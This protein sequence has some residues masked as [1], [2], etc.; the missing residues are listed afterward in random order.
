MN[1]IARFF[2][3]A[4]AG[5]KFSLFVA[6]SILQ[7]PTLLLVAPWW[8]RFGVVQFRIFSLACCRILFRIGL[9]VDGILPQYRPLLIT[10]NHISVF[11][12]LAFPALFGCRF[13]GKGEIAKYPL[14]GRLASGFG[15]MFIDR[16]PMKAVEAIDLIRKNL[17][18]SKSPFVIFPEGTTDNGNYI[19]PFKSAMFDF[20]KDVPD[21]KIQ[22][23]AITYLDKRGRKI[24][25]QV[26]ADEYA[27]F[28]N[29][30]QTREP[31]CKKELSVW[32][33][34]FMGM[35][36]GGF[37]IKMKLLPLFETTGLNRK[38]IAARLYDLTDSAFQEF[39]GAA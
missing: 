6:W 37:T 14:I 2:R 1:K 13:F 4:G 7:V 33:V 20:L 22:P 32:A 5:V 12:L 24:D 15:T 27:C 38:E 9:K 19:L 18:G 35:V 23:A 34:L 29:A 8:R 11:E 10:S 36:H 3:F 26:L 31:Y 28:V 17:R 30:K 16:N 25:P 21:A 39:G